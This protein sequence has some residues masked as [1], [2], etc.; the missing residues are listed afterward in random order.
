M[1]VEREDREAPEPCTVGKYVDIDFEKMVQESA[2]LLLV[3]TRPR[4]KKSG[5]ELLSTLIEKTFQ[6]SALWS[7]E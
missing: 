2:F 3:G 5:V 7:V 1:L 6:P 4:Q